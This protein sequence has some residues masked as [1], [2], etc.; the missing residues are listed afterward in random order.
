V[1]RKATCSRGA[2]MAAPTIKVSHRT[3]IHD[4]HMLNPERNESWRRE[5]FINWMDRP[6]AS[7]VGSGAADADISKLPTLLLSWSSNGALLHDGFGQLP[8]YVE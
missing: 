6:D 4:Q 2:L 1:I 7:G 8:R 5:N 3:R